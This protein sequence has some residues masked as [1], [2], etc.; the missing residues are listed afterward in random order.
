MRKTQMKEQSDSTIVI[1]HGWQ[2]FLWRQFDE[3]VIWF[4]VLICFL[5]L[6]TGV[7][8]FLTYEN[9]I[10][11]M[12]STVVVGILAI[13][14]SLCLIIGMFDLSIESTLAFSTMVAILL[15]QKYHMSAILV[16]PLILMIG[17]IIG[18]FNAVFI[19]K[20]GVNPFIQTLA[21]LVI[22]RGVVILITG[23]TTLINLPGWYRFIGTK[24]IF[25]MP[26]QVFILVILFIVFIIL[27]EK[28]PWGRRIYAIGSNKFAATASGINVQNMIMS[29]FIISSV[30][31]SVAGLIFTSR[32]GAVFPT[33]GEGQI[34]D[35][36]AA[37]VIGGI[38]LQGGRGKL[39]G[40]LGGAIFLS[41]ISTMIVWFNMPVMGVR[42]LRGVIILLAVL[43]DAMK[44][45]LRSR[46]LLG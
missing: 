5:A 12:V 18:V 9:F 20:L 11:L 45:K 1:K 31:A 25:K 6:V 33:V 40:V 8:G 16:I 35:V 3:N 17:L 39:V 30:L 26:L 44:N 46:F 22:L 38:S 19:V 32:V 10:S 21:V 36:M 28:T 34:F 37:A 2:M 41:F 4:I 24:S 42:A 15:F 14:E 23:G 29:A 27:L 7:K 43:L 13:G